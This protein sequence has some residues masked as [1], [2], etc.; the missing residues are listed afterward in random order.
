MNVQL[1]R[2]YISSAIAL[3]AAL[4]LQSCYTTRLV[5]T[6][7]VPMPPETMEGQDWYRDKMYGEYTAVVKT[8]VLTDGMM[9]KVP[10]DKCESGKLFSVEFTDTFG[11]NLLYL[12]TFGSRRKVK[13]KY[14]CMLPDL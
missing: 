2:V 6:H 7:G 8:S 5:S 1:R 14:V 4:L 10:K 11:G 3:I 12:V 13:I 9:I